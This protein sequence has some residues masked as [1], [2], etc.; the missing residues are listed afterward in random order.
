VTHSIPEAVFLSTRV[1]V[2][3]PRPGRIAEIIDID[4]PQPRDESTRETDR[5]YELVTHVRET[6]RAGVA[7]GDSPRGARPASAPTPATS[8]ARARGEG[9]F[10]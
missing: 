7:D 10:G 4:L 5:Y 3:S 2:M 8:E 6:L 1:V 9:S